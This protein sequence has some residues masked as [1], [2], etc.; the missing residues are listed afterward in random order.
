MDKRHSSLTVASEQLFQRINVVAM[1]ALDK[2][3]AT[4]SSVP[5]AA[6]FKKAGM[7]VCRRAE[8]IY[9]NK[10]QQLKRLSD[11]LTRTAQEIVMMT[12]PAASPALQ[13]H[14]SRLPACAPS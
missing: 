14:R 2:A 11:T 13:L 3:L 8:T 12:I 5:C 1:Q 9:T 4:V 6:L 10:I 7:T